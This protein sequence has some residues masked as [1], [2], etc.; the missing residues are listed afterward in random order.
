MIN[1]G[2]I[3]A[4]KV[5]NS[6]LTLYTSLGRVKKGEASVKYIINSLDSARQH[7]YQAA[8]SC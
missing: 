4:F 5:L 6:A 3:I 8:L 2:R 7:G 1:N